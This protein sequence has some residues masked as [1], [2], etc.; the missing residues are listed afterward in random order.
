MTRRKGK[1][2]G[3]Q[4]T[5]DGRTSAGQTAGQTEASPGAQA[6]EGG[7]SGRALAGRPGESPPLKQKGT[8]AWACVDSP[9]PLPG[10]CSARRTRRG[11]GAWGA[12]GSLL[13]AAGV[14]ALVATRDPEGRDGAARRQGG[15]PKGLAGGSPLASL[16]SPSGGGA[17]HLPREVP[18]AA[19]V[20]AGAGHGLRASV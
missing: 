15:S 17:G 9:S 19:R 10:G 16:R 12:A 7:R 5:P 3:Q 6:P 14:E 18:S 2:G 13:A 1:E 20:P 4:G 11:S 8:P